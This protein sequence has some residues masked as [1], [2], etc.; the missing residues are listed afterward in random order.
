MNARMNQNRLV[1]VLI[2]V[3]IFAW[4]VYHAVGAYFFNHN[5]L[6]A[7]VVMACVAGFLGFWGLMLAAR[8]RRMRKAQHPRREQGGESK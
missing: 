7:V 4:G 2:A 3:A 1:L 6:R 8:S 5:P